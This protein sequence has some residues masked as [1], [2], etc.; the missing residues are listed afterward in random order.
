MDRHRLQLPP[1][2]PA[3]GSLRSKQACTITPAASVC[4][5]PR[6]TASCLA[7]VDMRALSSPSGIP[8]PMRAEFGDKI[9]LTG[10]SVDRRSLQP[11]EMQLSL[12]WEG[13]ARMEQTTWSLCT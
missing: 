11:G 2:M 6:V 12:W 3:P 7:E 9:A 10:Y 5:P 4:Q 13:L 1:T 8:N